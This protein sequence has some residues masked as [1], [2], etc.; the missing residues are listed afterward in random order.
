MDDSKISGLDPRA[1]CLGDSCFLDDEFL[2]ST[3]ELFFRYFGGMRNSGTNSYELDRISSAIFYLRSLLKRKG[4]TGKNKVALEIGSGKGMKSIALADLFER[5]IG[6]EINQLD[7][8][9]A[10]ERNRE[11]GTGSV[12]FICGNATDILENADAHGIPQK[13]DVLIL[14]AVLEHLTL[15]ER[16]TVLEIADKVMQSGGQVLVMEAPNRLIPFDSHTFQGHFFNWLPDEPANELARAEAQDPQIKKMLIPW[17]EPDAHVRLARAGRGVSYHDFSDF[18][19]DPESGCAFLA[20]G[21]D[22]EMLNIEP[23]DYQQFQLFGYLDANVQNVNAFVFSRRWLDFIMEKRRPYRNYQIK[24][25][26][27]PHWPNWAKFDRPPLFWQPVAVILSS[28]NPRWTYE[29]ETEFVSEITL[30]F[31]AP[32]KRGRMHIFVNGGKLYEI[33][34]LGLVT[35]K[36][37]IWHNDHSVKL[38]V[39]TVIQELRIEIDVSDGPILFQGCVLSIS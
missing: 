27:S 17:H 24:K 8:R 21:F 11:F 22:V 32:E 13:I 10:E 36:P 28:C 9:Q 5:Y 3:K 19:R 37:T 16:T 25:F 29:A 15:Q 14:Y 2:L 6:I 33:D 18:L 35:S 12:D 34:V 39:N 26:I 23:F 31:G 38:T 4:V 30:L 20:D 1:L 7:L